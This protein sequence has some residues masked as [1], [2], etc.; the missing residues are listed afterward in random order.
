MTGYVRVTPCEA[1]CECYTE[2]APNAWQ[3]RGT[4]LYVSNVHSHAKRASFVCVTRRKQE[5]PGNAPNDNTAHL[6]VSSCLLL[7]GQAFLLRVFAM[8]FFGIARTVFSFQFYLPAHA[9]LAAV[10]ACS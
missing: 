8:G 5:R 1:A 2:K 6:C 4:Q 3:R 10:Q 7:P 9:Y